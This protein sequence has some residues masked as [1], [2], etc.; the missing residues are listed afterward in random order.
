MTTKA[1]ELR[2]ARAIAVAG[3]ALALAGCSVSSTTVPST[4]GATPVQL[5][6][7][8]PSSQG[9]ANLG[10]TS[11]VTWQIADL[12]L[13]SAPFFEQLVPIGDRLYLMTSDNGV[14]NP[15]AKASGGIWATADGLTW[16]KQS[17]IAAIQS[18]GTDRQTLI[19]ASP[20]GRGGAVVV[21]SEQTTD[22]TDRTAAWWTTDG[23]S[24][25]RASVEGPAGRMLSVAGRP[26]GLV[27]VGI[28]ATFSGEAA[29][30]RSTDGGSSW[31][32]VSLPGGGR[33]AVDVTVWGDRFVAIGRSQDA[34]QLMLWTSSDGA[35]WSLVQ[36]PSDP[37]FSPSHLIPFGNALVVLGSGVPGSAILTCGNDMTC[38]R[39]SVPD[40]GFM[41]SV[42]EVRA[43]AEVSGTIIVNALSGTAGT[44]ASPGPSADPARGDEFLASTDGRTWRTLKSSPSLVVVTS[45]LVVFRGR[46]V[47][48][49]FDPN[50]ASL[51]LRM[52]VGDLR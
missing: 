40:L 19:A 16:T 52:I 51:T 44:A 9:P 6:N 13:P 8:S 49:A 30:W 20:N 12:S 33:D 25:G 35:S 28:T 39:A 50:L 43:G 41:A 36:S 34:N 14:A 3:A 23:Q 17:D 15:T 7:T 42:T 29:A 48:V 11:S 2:V 32:S 47:A 46:L 21:G 38:A 45:N 10:Q 24:W 22:G 26:D 27:A 31:T 1:G 4:A 18:P 37:S 5:P